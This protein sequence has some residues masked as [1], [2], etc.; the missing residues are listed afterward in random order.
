M[1]KK[2]KGN[3]A[4]STNDNDDDWDA[5]LEAEAGKAPENTAAE[6]KKVTDEK[7]DNAND[8]TKDNAVD[9]AAAFLAAQGEDVGGGD[10]GGAK[11]KRKPKKKKGGGDNNTEGEGKVRSILLNVERMVLVYLSDKY[12][13]SLHSHIGI[14]KR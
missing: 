9:A 8:E 14:S 6:T 1:A 3:K 2:K 5:I 13:H 10:G 4:Q 11:K 12:F 7:K